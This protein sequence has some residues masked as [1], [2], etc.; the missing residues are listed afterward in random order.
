M[1]TRLSLRFLGAL[2]VVAASMFMTCSDDVAG[3]PDDYNRTEMFKVQ[4]DSWSV[5]GAYANI[6][7]LFSVEA[8]GRGPDPFALGPVDWTSAVLLERCSK[9]SDGKHYRF[10]ETVKVGQF[11]TVSAGLD[12]G[13]KIYLTGE[14]MAGNPYFNS[15]T[16]NFGFQVSS[17]GYVMTP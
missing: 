14:Q 6:N 11:K 7:L 5:P 8:F 10:T 17:N 16:N 13:G 2:A 4:F 12:W 1:K 9:T 3:P 15:P